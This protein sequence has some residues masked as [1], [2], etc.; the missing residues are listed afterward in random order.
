MKLRSTTGAGAVARSATA[1]GR[2]LV[3]FLAGLLALLAALEG[4]VRWNAPLF[5]AAS[6]RALAK[7]AMLEQHPRVD[8]LFLGTS[9]TQDGVSPDLV[10][11]TLEEAASKP[12]KLVGFNAAFPGSS[13]DALASL[14]RRFAGR[15]GLRVLA[16]ELSQPQ[17]GN[18][19][20]PWEISEQPPAT[21]EDR[22]ERGLSAKVC[23][24]RYRSAFLPDNLGRLPALLVFGPSLSGWET[25]GS[26]QVAS[27]LGH[28]EAPATGFDPARWQPALFKPGAPAQTLETEADKQA[29]R[30]AEI[31]GYYRAKGV[32]VVFFIPPLMRAFAPAPE[33]NTL[34][35]LFAEVARRSGC[36]VWDYASLDL[37]AGL[38]HD[39]SHLGREGRAH[40]S[41]AL[42][43][44]M[45]GLLDPK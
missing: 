24:V 8:I 21:L 11:R 41:R 35:P 10:T 22:L 29:T 7:A 34:K 38:F 33:R 5:A 36:E 42:A 37:P 1:P 15:P 23:L 2:R 28:K 20:A 14:A 30:L 26:D 12:G 32:R 4:L 6:H 31:A 44:H 43:M 19:P 9:R 13:L 3:L 18:E 40:F 39:P 27:W 16:I 45:A 25:L 17:L